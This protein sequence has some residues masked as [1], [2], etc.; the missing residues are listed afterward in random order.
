M[1]EQHLKLL[2]LPMK[3]RVT[4]FKGMV[5]SVSFDVYGCVQASLRPK[6][7]DSGKLPV[8]HWFDIKRLENDGKQIMVAPPHFTTPPGQETGPADKAALD[9]LP[10]RD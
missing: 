6:M 3:D 8:G 4:G 10:A 7:N 1:I 9:S 5:D 2:G